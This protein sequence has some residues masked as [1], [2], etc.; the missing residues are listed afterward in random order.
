MMRYGAVI[1]LHPDKVDEYKRLH[2]RGLAGGGRNDQTR[3]AS[4]FGWRPLGAASQNSASVNSIRYPQTNC[5]LTGL[6]QEVGGGR[7]RRP[8]LAHNPWVGARVGSHRSPIL[9]PGHLHP[10]SLRRARQAWQRGR[11]SLGL[12]LR[13][14]PP[15]CSPVGRRSP[16]QGQG[17]SG[18]MTPRGEHCEEGQGRAGGMTA[19]DTTRGK[20]IHGIASPS[21]GCISANT[22]TETL[23]N[24]YRSQGASP[25]ALANFRA[26]RELSPGLVAGALQHLLRTRTFVSVWAD[27]R[28]E[29]GR[30]VEMLLADGPPTRTSFCYSPALCTW[31]KCKVQGNSQLHYDFQCCPRVIC[32]III[33]LFLHALPQ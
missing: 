8:V 32:V 22:P 31:R 20:T 14:P 6:E 28:P 13:V 25:E 1:R 33:P 24:E 16:L 3:K 27:H 7:C 11:V 12:T 21:S 19:H 30:G 15:A 10:S 18:V 2:A 4:S 29:G 26:R 5:L 9:R 17:A 23:I